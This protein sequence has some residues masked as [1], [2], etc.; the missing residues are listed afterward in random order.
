MARFASGDHPPLVPMHQSLASCAGQSAHPAA[1]V[2]GAPKIVPP[3]PS[4]PIMR[5]LSADLEEKQGPRV[6]TL[7][8]GL[9]NVEG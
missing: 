2:R 9:R 7:A 3:H 6:A 5:R 1:D 4:H 8:V